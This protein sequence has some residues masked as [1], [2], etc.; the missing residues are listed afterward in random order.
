MSEQN[1][2]DGVAAGVDAGHV[3]LHAAVN[4]NGSPLHLEAGLGEAEA[5]GGGPA[6]DGGEHQ[7]RLHLAL[8]SP[9]SELHH[10]LA[11]A[12]GDGRHP[13]V[14]EDVDLAP[15]EGPCQLGRHL[16][17]FER[18]DAREHLDDGDLG[19]HGVEHF[20]ELDGDDAAADD[21][22]ALG[23]MVDV[24]H[25][26]AGEHAREVQA[27]QRQ[28]R[29][30]GAGRQHH[31]VGGDGFFL[32]LGLHGD[33]VRLGQPAL[34]PHHLNAVLLHEVLDA[35]DELADDLG[36]A[37]YDL[38]PVDGFE[39]GLDAELVELPGHAGGFRAPQEDFAGHAAAVETS[40]AERIHFNQGYF[41]AQLAGPYRPDISGRAASK[42]RH[43][44]HVC[45]SYCKC[46]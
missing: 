9:L 36:L 3:R 43:S 38:R 35:F 24:Q 8:L 12:L 28:P 31:A 16:L 10:V 1:S 11:V 42:Y 2:P 5:L 41:G 26:V 32:A 46:D 15:A 30:N 34:A 22:Q 33:D 44:I 7:L 4:F 27:R 39:L 45:C 6:P 18:D 40:S 25:F 17:V 23:D 13:R 19:T 14:G 29:R 20:G 21:G 37:P